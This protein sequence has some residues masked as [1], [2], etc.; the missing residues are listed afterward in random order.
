MKKFKTGGITFLQEIGSP[1]Q[2]SVS[3]PDTFVI[4]KTDAMI[5][6]YRHLTQYSPKTIMEIGMYEGGSLVWYDKLYK[7][8]K[9]VGLDLRRKPIVALEEYR[10]DKPHIATYYGRYQDKE[11]TRMAARQNFPDGIDL[12][13]DDA[14]HLYEQTKMT[15]KMLFPMVRAGGHYVIENWTWSH[16]PAYQNT[17]SIWADLPAM[18]NLVLELV[19]MASQSPVI[20]SIHVDRGL[21]CVRKGR[22]VFKEEMFDLSGC[23]R[24]KSLTVL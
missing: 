6:F 12:V 19:I 17:D 4:V 15:F 5:D 2:R 9:L 20:E 18:S 8:S 23:L 14:S 21:V 13:V 7:P 11:G 16:R 10:A 3:K 22:G 24:G 1:D